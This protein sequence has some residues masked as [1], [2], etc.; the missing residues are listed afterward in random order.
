MDIVL[1]IFNSNFDYKSILK[2]FIVYVTILWFLVV[3]W[4]FNDFK[5]RYKSNFLRILFFLF[6]MPFNIL[7]LIVYVIIKKE[8][9]EDRTFFVKVKAIYIKDADSSIILNTDFSELQENQLNKTDKQTKVNKKKLFSISI[10]YQIKKIFNLLKS[11]VLPIKY[12]FKRIKVN[13]KITS[14]AEN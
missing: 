5:K 7:G 11:K 12:I 1:Y 14:K 8:I 4:A 6:I 9:E 13:K 3:F 2:G 10:N